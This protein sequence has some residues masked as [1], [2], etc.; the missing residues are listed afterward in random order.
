M[1]ENRQLSITQNYL[2]DL[3]L[4]EDLV[5]KSD[6]SS[7]DTVIDIGAGK[8]IITNLLSKA[9]KHVISVELDK[10]LFEKLKSIITAKNV[11][12][13]NEDFLKMDLPKNTYKVFANIPFN[14]TSRILRK[15]FLIGNSPTSAYLIMQ[16]EAADLYLGNPRETQR[17]LLLKPFYSIEIF[18]NF[19]RYDFKPEP[20][21]DILMIQFKHR[22]IPAI[23]KILENE[24]YDFIVFGTMQC[25]RTLRLNFSKVFTGMQF[26]R[27]AENIKFNINSKPLDLNWE[28][29]TE[30]F[31]YYKDHVDASKK[32]LVIGSYG[33]HFSAENLEFRSKF[34]PR[35]I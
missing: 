2:T 11:T 25:K 35:R 22:E 30:L 19:N 18:H 31:K 9:C 7:S 23:E 16:K 4:V 34:N 32:N 29:W 20:S 12:L 27:L 14:E 15:L 28:Q 33:K 17:S 21:V 1:A 13:V 10:A 3:N 24:Y 6:I 8:G 26:K 5:N